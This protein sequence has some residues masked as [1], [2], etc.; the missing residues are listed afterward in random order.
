M[1]PSDAVE[2]STDAGTVS[3]YDQVTFAERQGG[4]LHL[5]LYVPETED[6]P[7]VV[8]VHGGGW[9]AETEDNIPDPARYAAEWDCAIASV[10]YRL[11][12]IAPEASEEITGLVDPDNPTPRGVF[13]DHFVDVKAA[14]R[15]LRAEADDYDYDATDVAAW[16]ASA[17]GHLALL[18]GLVDDVTDL[19]GDAYSKAELEKTVAPD[20]SGAVQAVVD[21][22]GI[23]DLTSVPDDPG[24]PASLLIG[25]PKSRHEER[26]ATASPVTHVTPEAPPMLVM[27]GREDTVVSVEQSRVLLDALDETEVDA[28]YY[29][30]HDLGHVWTHDG[31]E[32]IESERVAMD[33]LAADPTPAQSVR[34]TTHVDEGGA[35]EPLVD[36][37]PPAGPG[38][39]GQFLDRTIK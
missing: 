31:P 12:E 39:I 38:P 6:P 2:T 1:A 16:G 23:S 37:V 17:G 3:V 26:F 4:D 21:W 20:E 27:H 13:P 32:A 22:Y 36:G 9:F 19:A 5:D 35:G 14:I 34:E 10:G 15:W 24:T 11:S 28:V 30:L 33:L 25:G 7:L 8:Y 29:E 18:A